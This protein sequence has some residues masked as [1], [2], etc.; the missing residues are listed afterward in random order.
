MN[1][2]SFILIV[3]IA[4]WYAFYFDKHC[5]CHCHCHCIFQISIY[6]YKNYFHVSNLIIFQM[7]FHLLKLLTK[8]IT[9]FFSLFYINVFNKIRFF[10]VC[11][12]CFNFIRCFWRKNSSKSNDIERFFFRLINLFKSLLMFFFS[13]I[14]VNWFFSKKIVTNVN[15]LNSILFLKSIY[16]SS[17]CDL[18]S[19]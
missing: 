4:F 17:C 6:H 9:R 5:Y 10:F 19:N 2:T 7:Q 12:F 13:S 15:V 16:I 11:E 1:I 18:T 14:C 8:T 3:L